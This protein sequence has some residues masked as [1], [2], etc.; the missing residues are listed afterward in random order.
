MP[1]VRELGPGEA[2]LAAAAML[3]L[4]PHFGTAEAVAAKMEE[5]RGAGYRLAGSFAPGEAQA[6]AAMGF[7]FEDKL[8]HGRAIYIDDLVTRADARGG[9][10]ADALFAY[11][12]EVAREE[13]CAIVHLDSGV[14]ESRQ[15]A[16]R[17]YFNH[18]MRIASYHFARPLTSG[19]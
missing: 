15:D 16:H 13:D 18:G 10:H 7:R 4:R 14:Q 8:A 9:G 5:L 1:E 6:A 12:L 19:R 3:E 2:H 17:F 11:S